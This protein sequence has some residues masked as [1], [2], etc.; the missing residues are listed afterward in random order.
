MLRQR[1]PPSSPFACRTTIAIRVPGNAAPRA[2][3]RAIA[4]VVDLV[5]VIALVIVTAIVT[6][7][8]TTAIV[9][10]RN[11]VNVIDLV[12]AGAILRVLLGRASSL[13]SETASVVIV[14]SGLIVSSRSSRETSSEVR[15]VCVEVMPTRPPSATYARTRT[16]NMLVDPPVM[17]S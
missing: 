6:V 14:T 8:G 13:R 16:M 12:E 11:L 17:V 10:A 3:A 7:V 9:I 4:A 1:A 2:L 5:I 15:F